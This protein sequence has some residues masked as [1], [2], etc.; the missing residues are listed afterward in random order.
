MTDS[1]LLEFVRYTI[2]YNNNNNN[3]IVN[4]LLSNHK[5]F[6]TIKNKK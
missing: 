2:L 4:F 3:N 1:S 6:E 5:N